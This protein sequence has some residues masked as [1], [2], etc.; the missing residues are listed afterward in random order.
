M[1]RVPLLVLAAAPGAIAC[2]ALIGAD[3]PILDPVGPPEAGASAEAGSSVEAGPSAEASDLP[4]CGAPPP[5]DDGPV[6]VLTN[7]GAD[8][9]ACGSHGSPC[10]TIRFALGQARRASK[11]VV[12]VGPGTYREAIDLVPGV[13]IEGGYF[14]EKSGDGYT[15]I[16][17]C[18]SKPAPSDGVHIAPDVAMPI[19]AADLGGTAR[20]STLTIH[21]SAS[22]APS[23][24][25]YG[26]FATG[27][28]TRLE[29]VDVMIAPADAGDGL[30]GAAGA[31][32]TVSDAGCALGDAADAAAPGA[33]GG[34]ADP[35]TVDEAGYH[36]SAGAEG[37]GGESGENGGAGQ[38][39]ACLTCS[40][41]NTKCDTGTKRCGGPGAPGCG[42]GG[43]G[44]G[45]GG[46]GGGSSIALFAWGASVEATGGSLRSGAG[47]AG[48]AG[49]SG[50]P[51]SPGAT[52]PTGSSAISC[53]IACT[54]LLGCSSYAAAPGGAGSRGG[55]GT[56]GGQGGGGA[57]GWSFAIVSGNDASVDVPES[58]LEHSTYG[59]GGAPG[60][61]PGRSGKRYP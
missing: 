26:I 54:P 12:R 50:G 13:T 48:G 10:A 6:H 46:S 15:W 28:T 7:G 57:G 3:D 8:E 40:T 31:S 58:V 21:Q 1:V 14:V 52:G 30:G 2:N 41:C 22:P 60:G 45:A 25:V 35:G 38:S 56:A 32:G 37:G 61:A 34:G 44:G 59:A 18:L 17:N 11:T 43:G 51:G 5:P 4:D 42:G 53:G 20:L 19:V 47:G 9:A 16:P 27:A 33:T 29:L 24:S 39:G 49:G 55:N 36:P 23:E